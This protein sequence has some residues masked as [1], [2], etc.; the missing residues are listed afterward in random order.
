MLSSASLLAKYQRNTDRAL[1]CDWL[2]RYDFV[3][4]DERESR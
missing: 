4:D 1:N 3:L 2:L